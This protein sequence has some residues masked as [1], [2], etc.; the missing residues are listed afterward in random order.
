MKSISGAAP[1][2]PSD[3]YSGAGLGMPRTR[4]PW[5]EGPRSSGLAHGYSQPGGTGSDDF[6]SRRKL[7][8]RSLTT[9]SRCGSPHHVSQTTRERLP[10]DRCRPVTEQGD[11][12]GAWVRCH[13]S[14]PPSPLADGFSRCTSISE[15]DAIVAAVEEQERSRHRR[16]A[17][18][19]THTENLFRSITALPPLSLSKVKPLQAQA[20]AGSASQTRL[21]R[22][23]R[24][25]PMLTGCVEDRNGGGLACSSEPRSRSPFG[26]RV[27]R[28]DGCPA[29]RC[30][31]VKEER[32]GV[33]SQRPALMTNRGELQTTTHLVAR[34]QRLQETQLRRLQ[35]QRPER[36]TAHLA[37]TL[38]SAAGRWC[39]EHTD[40]H[41]DGIKRRGRRPRTFRGIE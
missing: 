29:A 34:L 20:T 40:L 24:T 7:A 11:G 18:A 16:M 39:R 41:D 13:Y 19:D 31:L 10:R 4:R 6:I 5:C 15:A 35:S 21:A 17:G 2:A 8:T 32:R 33:S 1:P 25:S 28:E 27:G 3:L 14:C 9:G 37:R 23:G 36:K 30:D 38:S 22:T 26:W 12:S